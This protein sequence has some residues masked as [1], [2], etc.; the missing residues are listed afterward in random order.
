MTKPDAFD[1]QQESELDHAAEE[2][3]SSEK[4]EDVWAIVIAV[5]V[6][7]LA[8]AFPEQIHNFFSKALYLF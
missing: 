8:V 6:F 3:F 5:G 7:L 4:R 1:N 2:V